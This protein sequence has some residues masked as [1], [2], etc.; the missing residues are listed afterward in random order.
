MIIIGQQIFGCPPDNSGQ[1]LC[2][3]RLSAGFL[4]VSDN[5]ITMHALILITG[6]AYVHITIKES[7]VQSQYIY[8]NCLLTLN[9]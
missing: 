4:V 9:C 1:N 6:G 8:I 7:V 5:G 2:Y 3:F